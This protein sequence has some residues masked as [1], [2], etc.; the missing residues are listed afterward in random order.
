[1]YFLI[2][3]AHPK[4]DTPDYKKYAGAHI[5]CWINIK[6][7][8]I[9]KR[10]AERLIQKQNWEIDNIEEEYPMTRD[11]AERSNG[12]SILSR[13]LLMEKF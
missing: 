8:E 2:Y 7:K 4:N 9:A 11:I 3:S 12:F 10:K 6:R 13:L 5:A 1:M